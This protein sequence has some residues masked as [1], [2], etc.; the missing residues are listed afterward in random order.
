MNKE[1]KTMSNEQASQYI[2]ELANPDHP[3]CVDDVVEEKVYDKFAE[4]LV[5]KGTVEKKM[6]ELQQQFE[7]GKQLLTKLSG[8]I[9]TLGS[10]LVGCEDERRSES[11]QKI[12]PTEEETEAVNEVK[13]EEG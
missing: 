1:L 6:E 11:A 10:I 2:N 13:G 3:F 9:E 8:E 12:Q 5:S 4:A 7:Q